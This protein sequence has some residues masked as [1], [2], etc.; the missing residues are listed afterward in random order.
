MVAEQTLFDA[1]FNYLARAQR[2]QR[3]AQDSLRDSKIGLLI[4]LDVIIEMI[5]HWNRLLFVTVLQ[6]VAPRL[7]R[8]IS[9][10]GCIQGTLDMAR[11]R[12]KLAISAAKPPGIFCRLAVFRGSEGYQETLPR[13]LS[14]FPPTIPQTNDD[15]RH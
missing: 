12:R 14:R 7:R 8:P 1:A 9:M 11:E 6:N 15:I 4:T 13:C 5:V 2:Y 10:T 3:L